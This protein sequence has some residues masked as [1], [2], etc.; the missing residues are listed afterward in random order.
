MEESSRLGMPG[1]SKVPLGDDHV[2][3]LNSDGTACRDER[4]Q[5]F[6][7]LATAIDDAQRLAWRLGTAGQY[8]REALDLYCRLDAAREELENIR[9]GPWRTPGAKLHQNG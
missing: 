4:A 3:M 7:E 1:Q 2:T 8:N 5:R 9:R 6:S